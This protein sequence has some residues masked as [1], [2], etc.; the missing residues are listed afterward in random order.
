MAAG[1]VNRPEDWPWSSCRA[2]IGLEPAP[3]WL[4]VDELYGFMLGRDR[5]TAARRYAALV[6]AKDDG[7]AG[8]WLQNLSGQ[9]FLGD[10]DFAE[11]T[12]Q[13]ATPQRLASP[14]VPARQRKALGA[15]PQTW[16]AWLERYDGDRN[17]A[18]H[19]AY[20]AGWGSM[21]ALASMCGLSV[22]QVSRV[23]RGAEGKEKEE[24]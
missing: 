10:A 24:T 3:H 21:P 6:G 17:A 12:R 22:A 23:I 9:I 15:G 7:D 16:P 11:R 5:S 4:A 14:Q 13:R 20:R 18:L 8:C 1:L 19:A 2:H